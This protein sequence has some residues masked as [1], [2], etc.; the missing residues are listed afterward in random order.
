MADA[1]LADMQRA[2]DAVDD[3]VDP[4]D[5]D[6][7]LIALAYVA[8]HYLRERTALLAAAPDLHE[9]LTTALEYLEDTIGPC[10]PS[11]NC[12]LHGLRAALAKADGKEARAPHDRR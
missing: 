3:A 10:E 5:Y 6:A 4:R 1:L 9:A 12:V 2:S 8:R 11:C 7:R